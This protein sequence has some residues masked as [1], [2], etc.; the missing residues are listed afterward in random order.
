[1]AFAIAGDTRMVPAAMV[2]MTLRRDAGPTVQAVAEDAK[3]R[4]EIERNIIV[5]HK[6]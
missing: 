4:R 6:Q 5:V 1:M 2:F 3:H